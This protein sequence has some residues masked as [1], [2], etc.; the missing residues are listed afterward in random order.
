MPS[1][2]ADQAGEGP[3]D[4]VGA[5]AADARPPVFLAEPGG[6]AADVIVLAGPEGRHAATVRRLTAG[7]RVDVTD[8]AGHVAECLVAAA[9]PDSLELTVQNLRFQPRPDPAV[10]VAQALPKGDRGQLAVELMTEAGVDGIVPWAAQRCVTR[11]HSDRGGR[12]LARWRATARESAKQARR[13]WLP[14]VTEPVGTSELARRVANA[15]LAVLLDPAAPASLATVPLP[16]SGEIVVIVGP[17]GGVAPAEAAELARAG[18]VSAHLGPTVLRT[19]SAGLAAA[20]VLFS[21][22]GRWN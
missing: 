2:A 7:E 8:G 13:A 16:P 5:A 14:A 21:R 22:C 3:A 9:R 11:W 1:T 12:A 20:S 19:S 17:E 10:V 4:G 15:A 6:F 18:A